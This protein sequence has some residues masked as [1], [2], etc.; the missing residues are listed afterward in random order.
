MGI[1]TGAVRRREGAEVALAAP[2]RPPVGRPPTA[3]SRAG[4]ACLAAAEGPPERVAATTPA[5]A[6]SAATT[7]APSSRRRRI[8]CRLAA[9][10]V[11]GVLLS[12]P[13]SRQSPLGLG[14]P[15]VRAT[16]RP[17]AAG[18]GLAGG[19]ARGGEG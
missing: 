14:G 13:C 17:C 19:D 8:A 7:S 9:S 18:G 16:L 4:A 10:P 12:I 5:I 3:A 6:A 15:R 11:C 1:G 2:G